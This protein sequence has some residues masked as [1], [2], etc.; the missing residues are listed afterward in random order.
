MQRKS[1]KNIVKVTQKQQHVVVSGIGGVQGPQ[2][3]PGEAATITVGQTTTL[4]AGSSA[5]VTN[6]GTSSAAVFNFGVPE[7]D[8]GDKGDAG[9]SATIT[10]GS[11]STLPAGSSATVTNTGTT[12]AAV[13][14]FGI[15]KGDKG[16]KG[17][18]GAGLQINGTVATYADLPNDL[19][20][21]DA[22]EAYFVQADGKLYVWTGTAF[23]PD[24][25]GTQFEGPQGPSGTIAVGTTSTL[26]EGSSATVT[27]TGTST[28][29]IFNFGIPK[30]D[31]GDKG[32]PG[33]PGLS[34]TVGG[35]INPV[36]LNNGVI[37][38]ANTQSS[39]NNYSIVPKVNADGV[40][41]IGRYID[42][43]NSASGATDYTTRIEANA[44]G[45]L[46]IQGGS[47]P[48]VS[49]GIGVSIRGANTKI[50]DLSSLNTSA[51]NNLVAAI[52]EVDGVLDDAAY[53]GSVLS[54]PTS[55]DYVATDNIQDGAVTS[56]KIDFTT[57]KT[58]LFSGTD[59]GG[60]S[61]TIA[62]TDSPT[63]YKYLQVFFH[64][65]QSYENSIFIKNNYASNTTFC[66]QSAKASING[67]TI[68]LL[69]KRMQLNSTGI[70]RGLETLITLVG[71]ST[72]TSSSSNVL[73]VTEV[74]GYK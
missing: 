39:G 53:V 37:T 46:Y 35:P 61:G 6:T 54:T 66:L 4:P 28:N 70:A 15:P 43:H 12:S 17:D 74:Y 65:D 10:V 55:V 25:Q 20:P 64:D 5:T 48:D 40:M 34:G 56:N 1:L 24:G 59:S 57:I 41:D 11:T 47:A 7:G 73:R 26:P 21:D 14:N 9:D 69:S 13:F 67:T 23:P 49:V 52:N 32:D 72:P 58:L 44:D 68:F 38:A 33:D 2:G 51:K 50:G 31:K 71:G 29:A 19:G 42:L 30:G 16:D 36:Y 3:I 18:A 27:N 62:F 8:K 22:G 45:N 60:S 63:N